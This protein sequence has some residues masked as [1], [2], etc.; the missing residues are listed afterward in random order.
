MI[1]KSPPQGVRLI[2]R[3]TGERSEAFDFVLT[4][5]ASLTSLRQAITKI[6]SRR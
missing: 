3:A 2:S 5:P 1:E 4:K 6:L